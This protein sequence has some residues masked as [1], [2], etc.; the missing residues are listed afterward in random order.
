MKNII[1]LTLLCLSFSYPE[2]N[3]QQEIFAHYEAQS[4]TPLLHIYFDRHFKNSKQFTD[5]E[6]VLNDL[7][8]DIQDYAE[9]IFTDCDKNKG[10]Y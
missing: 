4:F 6:V 1:I 9:I 7:N 2:F 5:F 8:E 3:E 10:I